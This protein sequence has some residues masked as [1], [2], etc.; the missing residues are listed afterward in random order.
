[1]ER[2]YKM[3]NC[4]SNL[5][6]STELKTESAANAEQINVERKGTSELNHF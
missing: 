6:I 4:R 2:N 3:G 1:M 5:T